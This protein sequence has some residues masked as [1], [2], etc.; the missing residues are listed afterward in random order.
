MRF[1]GVNKGSKTAGPGSRYELFSKGCLRGVISPCQGCFNESSWTFEGLYKEMDPEEAVKYIIRD[2]PNKQVTF[3]GG[4]PIV[5]IKGFTEVARLLKEHDPAFHI[6]M[7][8]SY[9]LNAL[10]KHG[11]HF[12]MPKSFGEQTKQSL[13]EYST[14]SE[15]KG[16]YT[17]FTIATPDEIKNLM[18]YVD[19]IVDGDYRFEKRMTT[20]KHMH[21]G[22]FIGSSNQRVID[23]KH[24]LKDFKT[25]YLYADV[26]NYWYSRQEKDPF[27]GHAYLD[28]DSLF[29][30]PYTERSRLYV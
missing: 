6:V 20:H 24:A 7:Y 9:K 23:C 8:T 4:E 25:S 18:F 1:I 5:Q 14:S 28:Q 29:Y 13:I 3:C 19:W 12:H 17:K 26:F 11:L 10:M 27:T 16:G 15:D 21:E 2:T 22:G 30:Y